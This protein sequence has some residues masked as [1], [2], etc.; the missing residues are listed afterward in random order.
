MIS[1]IDRKCGCGLPAKYYK[2]P[3]S[4]SEEKGSCNKYGRCPTYDEL[5]ASLVIA[6]RKVSYYEL[7]LKKIKNRD[8]AVSYQ[9]QSW[10]LDALEGIGGKSS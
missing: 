8:N 2:M 4:G 5:K 9:Y 1:L 7:T 6:E 10:A 3:L